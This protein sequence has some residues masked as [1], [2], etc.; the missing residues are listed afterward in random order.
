MSPITSISPPARPKL[1]GLKTDNRS[2]RAFS[3]VEVVLALGIVAFALISML[4]V[5]SVSLLS[6]QDSS[7]DSVF[8]LMT[9]SAMQEIRN[10]G[11]L[12]YLKA[13]LGHPAPLSTATTYYIYFD[14]NG[15]IT[16]DGGLASG[17]SYEVET[18][19]PTAN[20]GVPGIPLTS[21]LT[22]ATTPAIPAN[23]IYS[24]TITVSQPTLAQASS[25][26]SSLYV[27]K[28]VFAWPVTAPTANQKTR[29]VI[30]SL[31]NNYN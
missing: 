1:S 4:G 28:M 12:G 15:Q 20:T 17:H 16:A 14:V 22:T 3:L 29:T 27:I 10:V 13:N 25:P 6:H 9:E 23:T 8:T 19:N 11:F 30:A 21:A 18:L 26:T 7:V 2:I 24:C 5:M 31:S